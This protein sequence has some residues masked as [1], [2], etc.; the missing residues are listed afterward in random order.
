MDR[1]RPN[2]GVLIAAVS[3]ILL[4]AL[5]FLHW[6]GIELKNNGPALFYVY[7]TLPGRSAWDA[8]AYI[9]IALVI[10]TIAALGAAVLRIIRP[11]SKLV[12]LN[13]MVGILGI[14]SAL[15]ILYR[16]VDPP[17]F[18]TH[19]LVTYEAVV[20][21]PTFLALLAAVGI[22]CGGLWA[23]LGSACTRFR[24]RTARRE[25]RGFE[26]LQPLWRKPRSGGFSG[27]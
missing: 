9:P 8:L 24:R 20:R 14:F 13:L 12:I 6:F 11:R 16:I 10:T 23:T 3:A 22:A 4:F 25:G 26:S 19:E 27:T 1:F 2:I 15:L 7:G 5:T 17:D 18:G 21:P